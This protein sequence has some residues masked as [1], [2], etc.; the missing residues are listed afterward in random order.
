MTVLIVLLVF[1]LVFL[2]CG[3]LTIIGQWKTINKM[4]G[5]G[6]AA[7]VPV[8]GNWEIA[9]CC[10]CSIKLAVT[11]TALSACNIVLYLMTEFGEKS[12]AAPN[13]FSSP[14][15]WAVCILFIIADF[16]VECFVCMRMARHFGKSNGFAAGL[17]FL[18][19]IFLPILGFGS[20]PP[21]APPR[22]G[23]GFSP[24]T[25]PTY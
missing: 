15:F 4:G 19:F 24:P 23:K 1:C 20:A 13:A 9:S 21:L 5:R 18:P 8:F 22:T 3:I 14:A 7:I 10:G 16:V 2:A 12:G 17:I 6:W 11:Y 25:W